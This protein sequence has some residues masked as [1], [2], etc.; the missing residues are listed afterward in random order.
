MDTFYIEHSELNFRNNQKILTD[1]LDTLNRSNQGLLID[2]ESVDYVDSIGISIFVS[3]YKV[4]HAQKKKM[5]LLNAN[6]KVQKL[7][8]ITKLNTL[9]N[10]K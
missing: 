1:L 8:H 10:I 6:D 2:L 5:E 9:F 4:A 7:L 3:V